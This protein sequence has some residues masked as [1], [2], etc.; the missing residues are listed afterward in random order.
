[1]YGV[2]RL[3]DRIDAEEFSAEDER[4]SVT[5]ASQLALSFENLHRLTQVQG[6]AARLEQEIRD[7]EAAEAALELHRRERLRLK[8]EFLSHVSHELRSPLAAIHQFTTILLDGFGGELSPEQHEYLQVILRNS[9]Q[10]AAMIGDMLTVTR[11]DTGK[12][13]IHPQPMDISALLDEALPSLRIRASA[14]TILLRSESSLGQHLLWADAERTRQVLTNLIENAIK[15]TPA[16][17]TIAIRAGIFD[18]DSNFACLSVTDTG[19]GIN[20]ENLET[21]FE[22]LFQESSSDEARKGLGLGLYIA[23]DLVCRQSGRI[24]VASEVGRGSTF[25]FTL[26]LFSVTQWL[27][28]TLASKNLETRDLALVTVELSGP[29]ALSPAPAEKQL[30]D[31][32]RTVLERAVRYASDTVMPNLVPAAF[33]RQVHVLAVADFAGAH[34]L[35][36]RIRETLTSSAELAGIG[37]FEFKVSFQVRER[38]PEARSR[39]REEELQ[40]IEAWVQQIVQG[41]THEEVHA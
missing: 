20:P 10:L 13:P 22:R 17:G 25:F 8:D 4:L 37:G 23:K 39:S 14:K 30:A 15:F 2:L 21:V 19:C 32:V 27:L 31:V 41:Q 6:Y 36:N 18:D 26:P 34:G 28:P 29:S 9:R 12:L 33:E 40:E 1:V 16:G 5:L 11:A 3:T 35:S 7:R 38:P 24:W